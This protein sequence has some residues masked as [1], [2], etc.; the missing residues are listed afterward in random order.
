MAHVIQRGPQS[1]NN[2]DLIVL[3]RYFFYIISNKLKTK[4]VSIL[5]RSK[6]FEEFIAIRLPYNF[7][8]TIV[9]GMSTGGYK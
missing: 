5:F 7:K 8:S 9:L 6:M 3:E 1:E 2:L 4:L